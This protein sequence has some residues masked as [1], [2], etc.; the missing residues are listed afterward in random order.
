MFAPS[1]PHLFDYDMPLSLKF[2]PTQ[3][4]SQTKLNLKFQSTLNMKWKGGGKYIQQLLQFFLFQFIAK[5]YLLFQVFWS[6]W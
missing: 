4:S 6:L 1:E 5:I 2:L 3:F